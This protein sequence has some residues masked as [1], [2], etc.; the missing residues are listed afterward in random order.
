MRQDPCARWFSNWKGHYELICLAWAH[1]WTFQASWKFCPLAAIRNIWHLTKRRPFEQRRRSGLSLA[2]HHIFQCDGFN[3]RRSAP[4]ALTFSI[5]IVDLH[6]IK[7]YVCVRKKKKCPLRRNHAFILRAH[8]RCSFV[9][10]SSVDDLS[11]F[12]AKGFQGKFNPCAAVGAY[13]TN[14][15]DKRPCS[16][17]LVL[18]PYWLVGIPNDH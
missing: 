4:A 6:S 18:K 3:R 12:I 13:R 9:I 7:M 11:T 15:M 10:P 8:T 2:W 14:C 1:F 16:V 17:M 5:P